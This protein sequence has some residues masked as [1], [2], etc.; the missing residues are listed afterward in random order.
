MLRH[1]LESLI[2][3]LLAALA[4]AQHVRVQPRELESNKLTVELPSLN[5]TRLYNVLNL[6]PFYTKLFNVSKVPVTSDLTTVTATRTPADTV[7]LRQTILTQALATPV[8]HNGIQYTLT[9]QA[10]NGYFNTVPNLGLNTITRTETPTPS[11]TDLL[12]SAQLQSQGINGLQILGQ[13]VTPSLGLRPTN[14]YGYSG[15]NQLIGLNNLNN[16]N[17]IPGLRVQQLPYSVLQ[18]NNGLYNLYNSY[19]SNRRRRPVYRRPSSNRD[20][21]YGSSDMDRYRQWLRNRYAAQAYA[22]SPSYQRIQRKRLGYRQQSVH[23]YGQDEGSYYGDE[24]NDYGDDYA[25]GDDFGDD[26][27]NGEELWRK[28]SDDDT[29]SQP[30]LKQAKTK[31]NKASGKQKKKLIEAKQQSTQRSKRISY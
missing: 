12:A 10:A 20:R 25:E 4:M 5:L 15:L 3:L 31:A 2:L 13:Q 26:Y 29:E 27:E 24:V 14:S 28:A 19:N 30:K 21:Y 7:D 6:N 17:N 1:Q 16:L 18:G 23:R 9:P 11:L 22:S 8:I